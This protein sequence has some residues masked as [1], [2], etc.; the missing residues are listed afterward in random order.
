[1][2]PRSCPPARWW[3]V[4]GACL[5]LCGVSCSGTGALH[6]V[7]GKV[8]YKSSPLSGALVTFH[9]KGSDDLK[10]VR[11]TG[12]TTEDGSFTLTTGE[13]EGAPAGEYVV[14]IIC[15]EQIRPKGGISAAP[16]ETRDRLGGAYAKREA[17]RIVVEVKSGANQLEPFDLK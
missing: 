12:L 13:K 10:A 3:L 14:T 4:L 17:S 1:M 2:T 8:I 9:P 16:P 7:Q 11:P 15:S 5:S 6:P